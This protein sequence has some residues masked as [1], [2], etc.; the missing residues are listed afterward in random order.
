[1]LLFL[2]KTS[3]SKKTKV[4][5]SKKEEIPIRYRIDP[6]SSS[7][8]PGDT[9]K[10]TVKVMNDKLDQASGS[11]RLTPPEKWDIPPESKE[12]GPLKPGEEV[13]LEFE[14]NIPEDAETGFIYK[15][16]GK[17]DY[18]KDDVESSAMIE[19]VAQGDELLW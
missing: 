18:G 12:Y 15:V 6:K 8:N 1:M 7:Q 4:S 9:V 17:I 16:A 19:L 13:E 3:K 14:F 10:Y 11:V 2:F 5:A